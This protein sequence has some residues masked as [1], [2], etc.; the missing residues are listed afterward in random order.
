MEVPP[1]L[2]REVVFAAEL[3]QGERRLALK[4]L[5]LVPDKHL[6]LKDP[7]LQIQVDEANEGSRD[8]AEI[9]VTAQNMAR[10]V[11]L[12]TENLDLLFGDNYFDVL[13]G[14]TVW[15]YTRIPNGIDLDNLRNQLRVRTL[16][17]SYTH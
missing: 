5:S 10:F 9:K 12:S 11:E 16:Y 6:N 8:Y 7:K 13:P 2:V 3:C 4:V 14:D 15:I 17:D 1:D